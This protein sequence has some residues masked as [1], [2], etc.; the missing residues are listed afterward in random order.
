MS[1]PS[2]KRC[3]LTWIDR[4]QP[5]VTQYSVVTWQK[6]DVELL[7]KT[8]MR[9]PLFNTVKCIPNLVIFNSIAKTTP[10]L[11]DLIGDLTQKSLTSSNPLQV[12][13]SINDAYSHYCWRARQTSHGRVN[14]VGLFEF[15]KKTQEWTQ[16]IRP[17]LLR[18]RQKADHLNWEGVHKP[19]LWTHLRSNTPTGWADFILRQRFEVWWK[20]VKELVTVPSDLVVFNIQGHL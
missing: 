11:F 20:I 5:V 3:P 15:Q 1:V 16:A 19:R 2:E 12:S 4:W 7:R 6:P 8:C 14:Q 13:L 10:L 18:K 9:N 17:I